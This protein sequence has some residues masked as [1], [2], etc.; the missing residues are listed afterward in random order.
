[1]EISIDE[2]K[3]DENVTQVSD[4]LTAVTGDLAVF[5]AQIDP[6][7]HHNILDKPRTHLHLLATVF[8]KAHCIESA[9]KVFACRKFR[10]ACTAAI[11]HRV[12]GLEGAL[13]KAPASLLNIEDYTRLHQLISDDGAMKVLRHAKGLTAELIETLFIL[14]PEYRTAGVVKHIRHP[15]EAQ[16]VKL[17]C[18]SGSPT[19]CEERRIHLAERL[20]KICV[21]EKFWNVICGELVSQMGSIPAPPPINHPNFYPVTQLVEV[22]QLADKFRNCLRSYV[23][24][25]QGGSLS[26][27]Q[28]V[29]GDELAVIGISPRF[30]CN[31][32]VK[33]IKGPQNE[34]LSP[35]LLEE[36]TEILQQ[37]DFVMWTPRRCREIDDIPEGIEHL[38]N[39]NERHEIEKVCNLMINL[40]SE[41]A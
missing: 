27:Y 38:T 3:A 33:E 8:S 22:L 37:N 23:S 11:G 4:A 2:P 26:L 21:A 25:V 13:K 40:I 9:A 17:A 18:D 36:I 15:A 34:R 19:D 12:A 14:P 6:F 35:K 7:P 31:G 41:P 16:I 24:E 1:M 39:C 20:S 29:R 30:G 28:F 5:F 32:C 10:D